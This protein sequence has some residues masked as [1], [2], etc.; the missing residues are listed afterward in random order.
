MLTWPHAFGDWQDVPH[1]ETT[2]C[3]LARAISQH[4]QVLINCYDTAHRHHVEQCLQAS[5]TDIERCRLHVTPSNDSWARDH[6]P[7]S[8][9]DSG[10]PKILDFTFN[11]WGKYRYEMDNLITKRLHEAGFFGATPYDSIGMVLEGGS[12]ETDGK[13]TLLTTSQCLCQPN[14]NPAL[15]RDD[16]VG[17]LCYELGVDRILWLDY[18][19]VSGDDTDGHIDMLA[20]FCDPG[21]IAYHSCHDLNDADFAPLQ[22]MTEQLRTFRNQSGEPYRL[23]RLPAPGVHHDATGRRLPAS[24]ANFLII[25]EAVL[26]PQYADPADPA[27]LE[28]LASC[29]PD[30]KIVGID[31]R[32]LIEQGGSLHCLTMQLPSGTLAA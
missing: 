5:H 21:T 24:Y 29:F 8:I 32:S 28:T 7:I 13:G 14:R 11:G 4:Q 10:Y 9:Q 23:I 27:A 25:N 19:Q 15:S 16:I 1:V 20:R 17:R 18:G 6:G 30:R 2:F 26:V 31:C 12:I 22:A 3:A